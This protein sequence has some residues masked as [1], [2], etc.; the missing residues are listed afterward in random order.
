M[1]NTNDD[2]NRKQVTDFV[3]N[4]GNRLRK[5]FRTDIE[6]S[7]GHFLDELK[8]FPEKILRESRSR[9]DEILEFIEEQTLD[10]DT[11]TKRQYQKIEALNKALKSAQEE[12]DDAD[13]RAE[14]AVKE[15][16]S[17]ENRQLKDEI[18]KLRDENNRLKGEQ[19]KPAIKPNSKNKKDVSSEKERKQKT[20]K[21]KRKIL[22][23]L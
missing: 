11:E 4:F 2:T 5:N 7:L 10:G 13:A 6:S 15:K 20:A 21:N 12:K 14:T 18:Q 3:N 23:E 17:S 16:L 1:N 9:Q 19:G 22:A 8:I